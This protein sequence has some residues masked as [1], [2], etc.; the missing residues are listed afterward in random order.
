MKTLRVLVVLCLALMGGTGWLLAHFK[1]LQ[2]LGVPGVKVVAEPTFA[3][4]GTAVRSNS[5]YLPTTVLDYKSD[6]VPVAQIV[7]DW[8]PPDT[9]FGQRVYRAADGFETAATVVLMGR[10]R[11]SLHKP[12]YCLTGVGWQILKTE[13]ERIQMQEPHPY[14]LQVMKLTSERSVPMADGSERKF[15]GLF[16]YWFVSADQLTAR[17]NERM[18]WMARDLMVQGVLQRWAYVSC[19]SICPPGLEDATFA[20]MSEWIR[21]AVPEFQLP[22]GAPLAAASEPAP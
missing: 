5:V 7:L 20:R 3:V 15:S 17:H 9:T 4:D 14:E 16:V 19:F 10:D 12:Q 22:A 11:T 1:Q 8:L 18:W 6:S 2:R 13:E 21:A